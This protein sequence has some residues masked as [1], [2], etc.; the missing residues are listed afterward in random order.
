MRGRA[1]DEYHRLR[2][3]SSEIKTMSL[4]ISKIRSELA[5]FSD[6]KTRKSGLRFF[7]E[8]VKLHGVK[9]SVV[10]KIGKDAFKTLADR[11]KSAIFELC[12]ELWRTGYMEESLIACHWSFRV[13]KEFEPKDFAVF[14]KWVRRYVGNW[15]SCDTLCNH[16]IGDF[17][18]RYPD[19]LS[20][21]I[22][23][24]AS[25]NRWMRRAAAVS[26]IIP[27][28]HGKFLDEILEIA[29]I[30]LL[31]QDDLVQKGYGWMLKAVSQ[32]HQKEL[33]DY[34]MEKKAIM[35]RTAL[36]YAIEKMPK[37]LRMQAMGK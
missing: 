13:R 25:K 30:L 4:I 37:E 26:L 29:D 6:E 10:G 12:E 1:V 21:L 5:E 27:A 32:A 33:F 20:N 11:S 7:K 19:Y 9:S 22:Q 15:A 31:D 16:T 24:A 14:E 34:I 36:R 28:R 8:K 18:E 23:W 3:R 2:N 35:P 17:L